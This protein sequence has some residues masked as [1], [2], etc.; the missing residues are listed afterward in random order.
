MKK[1]KRVIRNSVCN[2]KIAFTDYEEH[3]YDKHGNCVYHK[4]CK[5]DTVI[6]ETWNVFNEHNKLSHSKE[7]SNGKVVETWREYDEYGNI[8]KYKDSYGNEDNYKYEYF[9]K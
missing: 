1:V 7:I 6:T 2:A 3:E 9:D 5:G 8:T 4:L